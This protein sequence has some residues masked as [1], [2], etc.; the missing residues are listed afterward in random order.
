MSVTLGAVLAIIAGGGLLA[1][2]AAGASIAHETVDG[3]VQVEW[4]MGVDTFSM[5]GTYTTS[6][7]LGQGT[8]EAGS[9]DAHAFQFIL[10]RSDGMQMTGQSLSVGANTIS[11]NLTGTSDIKSANLTL[12]LLSRT[13]DADNPH[14]GVAQFQLQGSILLQRWTGYGTVGARCQ[15]QTVVVAPWWCSGSRWRV[16]A[17]MP[18]RPSLPASW[19]LPTAERTS[20]TREC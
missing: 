11:V 13:P 15:A 12:T 1:A 16:P 2:P 5:S 9:V 20:Q 14:T 17:T 10:V 8:I 3:L 19:S 7:Q 6:S 18:A 4:Q